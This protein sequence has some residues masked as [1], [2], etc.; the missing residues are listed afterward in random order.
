MYITALGSSSQYI[1]GEERVAS[2]TGT[3]EAFIWSPA[4]PAHGGAGT[5]VTLADGAF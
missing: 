5:G 3:G 1:K 4:T 2:E